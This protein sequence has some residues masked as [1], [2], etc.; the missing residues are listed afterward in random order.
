M[1]SLVAN[2]Q[3]RYHNIPTAEIDEQ[4]TYQITTIGVAS[5]FPHRAQANSMMDDIPNFIEENTEAEILDER[6]K[7]R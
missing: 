4:E 7:I 3:N 2:V 6:L 5:I 1:K